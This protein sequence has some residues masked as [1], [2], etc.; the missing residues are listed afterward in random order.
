MS[1]LSGISGPVFTAT[2]NQ[3]TLH[4]GSPWLPRHFAEPMTHNLVFGKAFRA[5]AHL[6][7]LRSEK[8]GKKRT[9]HH[10]VGTL[11]LLI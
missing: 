9:Q 4:T 11:L 5:L 3:A 10:Q 7:A 2:H 6:S 1:G 8:G